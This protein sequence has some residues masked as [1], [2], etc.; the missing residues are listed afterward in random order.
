MTSFSFL[1]LFI[2]P[3]FETATCFQKV[4]MIVGKCLLF[5]NP[6]PV[7]L[8]Y[9]GWSVSAQ[10]KHIPSCHGLSS[11]FWSYLGARSLYSCPT[12][13]WN[14]KRAELLS[15]TTPFSRSTH[16]CPG[17]LCYLG[18]IVWDTKGSWV[19]NMTSQ[20]QE[21]VPVKKSSPVTPRPSF[22]WLASLTFVVKVMFV[23][24]DECLSYF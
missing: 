8:G 6:I 2:M 9:S 13:P 21:H 23:P 14:L 4:Q 12:A 20:V 16:G 17:L 5:L 10:L 7:P 18:A 19:K 11:M 3:H 1:F 22:S 15:P 24:R